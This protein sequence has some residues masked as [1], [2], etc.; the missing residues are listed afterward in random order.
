MINKDKILLTSNGIHKN[1]K[2][3]GVLILKNQHTKEDLIKMDYLME[4]VK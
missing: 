2:I 3:F 4:K 1:H